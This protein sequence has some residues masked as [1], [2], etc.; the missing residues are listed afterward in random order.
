MKVN[1]MITPTKKAPNG[2]R[3]LLKKSNLIIPQKGKNGNSSN[4][5]NKRRYH[6]EDIRE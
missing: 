3:H 6:R 5:T 1:N 2:V 4:S